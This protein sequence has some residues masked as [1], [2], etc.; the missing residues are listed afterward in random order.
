MPSST[1]SQLTQIVCDAKAARVGVPKNTRRG[2]IFNARTVGEPL[3][4]WGNEVVF[5]ASVRVPSADRPIHCDAGTLHTSDTR[6]LASTSLSLP[7]KNFARV[8]TAWGEHAYN[9]R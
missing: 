4:A 6:N 3:S 5:G 8:D 9:G 2:C 1:H 7:C